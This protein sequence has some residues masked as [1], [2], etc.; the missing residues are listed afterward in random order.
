ME[1][2]KRENDGPEENG[3]CK[4]ITDRVGVYC[5]Q[6]SGRGP[7]VVEEAEDVNGVQPLAEWEEE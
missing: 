1:K 5:G 4:F 7:A 6:R 3:A 2:G